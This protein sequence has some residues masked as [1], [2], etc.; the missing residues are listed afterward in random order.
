[1]LEQSLVEPAAA[2]QDHEKNLLPEEGAPPKLTTVCVVGLG[3]V[4]LPVAVEFGKLRPT[5]GFDLATA[6]VERLKQFNDATG[7][8]PPDELRAARHL[9]VTDDPERIGEAD[10][11][12]IAVPTPVN[13]ARQPD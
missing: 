7:E 9:T 5:I 13:D 4:G 8:V 6:K 2:T 1:M 11:V 12:I 3:Y 10:F